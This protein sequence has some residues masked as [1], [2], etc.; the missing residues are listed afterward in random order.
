MTA[1]PRRSNFERSN[2]HGFYRYVSAEN[3]GL[4]LYLIYGG[5]RI[6]ESFTWLIGLPNL[7]PHWSLGSV[8]TQCTR[9]RSQWREGNTE[10]CG[11]LPTSSD[12]HQFTPF[13]FRLYT[14]NGKRYVFTWDKKR[15]PNAK[16]MLNKLKQRGL[17]IV[18]NIKPALL[19][20]HP[21]FMAESG[22]FL[23]TPTEPGNF[24]V[25]GR[26]GRAVDFTSPTARIWWK[27][28]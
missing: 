7:S 15:F 27:I 19:W 2:Y 21:K 22:G 9:W 23:K 10:L 20:D 18:A 28:S 6:V 13:R 16:S 3:S 26:S 12:S 25:L 5:N 14:K 8:S 11:G 17:G 4:D 1:A 24:A